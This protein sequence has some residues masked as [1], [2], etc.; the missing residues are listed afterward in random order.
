MRTIKLNKLVFQFI[1]LFI[2]YLII[3]GQ[4]SQQSVDDFREHFDKDFRKLRTDIME[5]K[6]EIGMFLKENQTNSQN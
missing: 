5:I 3:I 6:K 2:T 4:L 1:G